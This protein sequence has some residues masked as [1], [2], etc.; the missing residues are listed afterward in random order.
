MEEQNFSHH[1]VVLVIMPL[2]RAHDSSWHQAKM[3]ICF[4]LPSEKIITMTLVT[5][6]GHGEG[7][8]SRKFSPAISVSLTDA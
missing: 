6:R 2:Y 8:C 4:N 5:F 1:I 7:K 3:F